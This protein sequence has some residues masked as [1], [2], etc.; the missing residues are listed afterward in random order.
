MKTLLVAN[1]GEICQRIMVTA[2][3]M[4]IRCV[5][6]YSDS[7][8]HGP[9]VTQ[10]DLA[11]ALGGTHPRDSYL[12]IDKILAAAHSSGADAIHPGYGFLSENADFAQA[13]L[14]AGITFVG[15]TPE[16]IRIMGN[17]LTAKELVRPLKVPTLES[18]TVTDD[19]GDWLAAAEAMKFPV[20][21]KAAAG[22]GG[23]GMRIVDAPADLAESIESA[24]R[25]AEAGFGNSSVFIEPYLPN[26]RHIEV[27]VFGDTRG[28]LVH[29]FERE[30]SIQR[31]HQ[32]VIEESPS[33]VLSAE[34]RK[35]MTDAALAVAAS[36][37]YVGA[38]TVEFLVDGTDFYF[39]EMNT[40]LQVEHPVTEML[41]GLDLVRWQLE[42]AQQLP[43][44]LTQSEI[45]SNGHAIEA[46]LCAEIPEQDFLP[47][48]GHFHRY[49]HRQPEGV[50]FDDGVISGSQMS[51]HY[52]NLLAKVVAHGESR[53][54]A[55]A[56]LI[57]ALQTMQ[58][59]GVATNR[60]YLVA[61]LQTEEFQRG[62]TPTTFLER[63]SDKV[64]GNVARMSAPLTAAPSVDTDT[65][66]DAPDAEQGE[67]P[68]GDRSLHASAAAIFMA[69]RRK[70]DSPTQSFA[71]LGWRNMPSQPNTCQFSHVDTLSR[72][73]HIYSVSYS[74]DR[75]GDFHVSCDRA[76]DDGVA[77]A[78]STASDPV[79][80]AP[81]P[82][83]TEKVRVAFFP[84]LRG[85][86]SRRSNLV[87]DSRH[88]DTGHGLGCFASL[89]MT[90][91]ERGWLP[92]NCGEITL[93]VGGVRQHFFVN[94]VGDN[95]YINDDQCQSD[96]RSLGRPGEGASAQ[97]KQLASTAGP[98]SPMP[99]QIV[100]V[101][102][103]L[104]DSVT[105]GQTL[106]ILEAMKME[107]RIEAA[108]DSIVAEIHVETGQSVDAHQPLITLGPP[109]DSAPV[110]TNEVE[111]A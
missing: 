16:A 54:E 86:V 28:N 90:G 48:T 97:T 103:S 42:V 79:K 91:E 84:S 88:E 34:T 8:A 6:A 24:Q 10:A 33:I 61:I 11:V 67:R 71:P 64:L 5:A 94:I 1:R 66:P 2:Q 106:V 38:G 102:V 78:E 15:P 17:K 53:P 55:I 21:V 57:R 104:G 107:H 85:G 12:S 65:R 43:L 100:A 101:E 82:T 58:L 80:V 68:S 52:D 20:L 9:F 50:R 44:P 18:V 13:C 4:G 89:A 81:T 96:F 111:N 40:R 14:D 74:M 92:T 45:V 109:L 70:A 32:K 108:A 25:E 105:A 30:C 41:T 46:R 69:L 63:N 56:R 31:R 35:A 29:L 39:L 37:K 22:G 51:S 77:T 93:E 75:N 98:T 60:D 62:E 19:P 47:T 59:H 26:S 87:H 83:P 36:V 110:I 76:I 95:V 23:R 99:G 7:D 72:S 3:S 27:Q 73:E 49:W